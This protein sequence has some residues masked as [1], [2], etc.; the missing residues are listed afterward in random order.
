MESANYTVGIQ[1]FSLESLSFEERRLWE[2]MNNGTKEI[3][4]ELDVFM[5]KIIND[6]AKMM[7]LPQQ[8]QR[9]LNWRNARAHIT[10]LAHEGFRLGSN[11][12]LTKE[13]VSF[14][15]HSGKGMNDFC[16]ISTVEGGLQKSFETP[17]FMKRPEK[18]GNFRGFFFCPATSNGKYT[19]IGQDNR[20]FIFSEGK[21]IKKFVY[22]GGIFHY[23]PLE[24]KIIGDCLFVKVY[25]R[26]GLSWDGDVQKL[27]V[28]DL[29][30]LELIKDVSLEFP[31][32]LDCVGEEGCTDFFDLHPKIC[33]GKEYVVDLVRTGKEEDR[34]FTLMAYPLAAF[35][36][37]SNENPTSYE[38]EQEFSH[39]SIFAE[40]NHFIVI[41]RGNG[42][43]KVKIDK[44]E[45]F[46]GK[47]EVTNLANIWEGDEY[48]Y[49]TVDY[50]NKKVA[51]V[52]RSKADLKT[53]R[54]ATYDLK[55]NVECRFPQFPFSNLNMFQQMCKNIL[56]QPKIVI[57]EAEPKIH[58]F[59]M[60]KTES[61]AKIILDHFC[62]DYTK[63]NLGNQ[64]NSFLNNVD[65]KYA[66][67]SNSEYIQNEGI[68]YSF[69]HDYKREE[70]VLTD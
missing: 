47:F 10:R 11:P 63:G 65:L 26:S 64:E 56:F 38:S 21:F 70:K 45:I 15:I 50:K 62:L 20:I 8:Y 28:Y 37:K 53:C 12:I 68:A 23:V 29:C 55:T 69:I 18:E 57:E 39:P 42:L 3:S 46:D 13:G 25:D 24:L 34:D 17:E 52:Y 41:S 48:R 49:E 36:D 58:Y 19:A 1:D 59:Q 35:T 54:I 31:T 32:P 7:T 4:K 61:C 67:T 22:K 2:E 30:S 51:C 16:H 44:V 9:Q 6:P 27:I 43:K 60:I 66:D 40:D 5:K 14:M 33:F